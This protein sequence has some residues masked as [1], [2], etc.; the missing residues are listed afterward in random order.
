HRGR[1]GASGRSRP[2]GLQRAARCRTKLRLLERSADPQQAVPEEARTDRSP[3]TGVIAGAAAVASGGKNAAGARGDH[4]DPIDGVGQEGHTEADSLHDDDEVCG[5]DGAQSRGPTPARP[6]LVDGPTAIPRGA[7]CPGHLLHSAPEW[8]PK[9]CRE[10]PGPKVPWLTEAAGTDLE[11][12]WRGGG[13][14]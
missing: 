5:G 9:R 14:A 13:A 4:G 2:T 6:P 8:L 3:G 10:S 11:R 7:A 12:P 1:D